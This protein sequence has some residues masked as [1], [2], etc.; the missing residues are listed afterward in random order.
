MLNN[1]P[2]SWTP[3]NFSFYENSTTFKP[4]FNS[5]S[6]LSDKIQS[7]TFVFNRSSTQQLKKRT[8][9]I[10]PIKLP[11]IQTV[12]SYSTTN[13]LLRTSPKLSRFNEIVE[14]SLTSNTSLAS[15]ASKVSSTFTYLQPY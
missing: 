2:I 15:Q 4:N 1:Q 13:K 6:K 8:Q 12:P 10:S 5:N 9:S 14:S 3:H 11:V 7:S